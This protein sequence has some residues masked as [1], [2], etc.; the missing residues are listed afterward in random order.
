M[1]FKIMKNNCKL[2]IYK[3]NAVVCKIKKDYDTINY[4]TTIGIK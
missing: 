2:I 4:E 3:E 1:L